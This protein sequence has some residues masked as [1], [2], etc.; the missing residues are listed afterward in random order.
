[1]SRRKASGLPSQRV[2]AEMDSDGV[3]ARSGPFGGICLV[4][5]AC[6][7]N[8][9]F[10]FPTWEMDRCR[11]K[12]SCRPIEERTDAVANDLELVPG[13]HPCRMPSRPSQCKFVQSLPRSSNLARR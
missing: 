3:R 1:M 2:P 10:D 9:L 6:R 5:S 13:K 11:H 12:R 4:P 7:V 8:G